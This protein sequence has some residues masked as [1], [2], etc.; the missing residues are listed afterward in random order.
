MT[1]IFPESIHV[2]Q[3]PIVFR[4]TTVAAG[5]NTRYL[6]DISHLIK[7]TTYLRMIFF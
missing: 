1:G 2:K 3:N 6:K 4:G 5:L 7:L